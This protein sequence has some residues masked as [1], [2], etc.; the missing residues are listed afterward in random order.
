[1]AGPFRTA[2]TKF[3][4]RCLYCPLPL[5]SPSLAGMFVSLIV[6]KQGVA[7][8]WES[9]HD[10]SDAPASPLQVRRESAL[11]DT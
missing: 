1:M 11:L 3:N 7:T 9:L 5:A 4:E 2:H 8:S 6:G 10:L